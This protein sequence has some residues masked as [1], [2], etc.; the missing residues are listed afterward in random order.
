MIHKEQIT[1][2][3]AK[4]SS[5]HSR[6]QATK[7]TPEPDGTVYLRFTSHASNPQ[8]SN[9]GRQVRT[10]VACI[11]ISSEILK[12]FAMKKR[13]TT[14]TTTNDGQQKLKKQKNGWDMLLRPKAK[15]FDTSRFQDIVD[16]P[17]CSGLKLICWLVRLVFVHLWAS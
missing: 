13:A 9:K 7:G 4:T 14:T 3:A 2:Y 8:P 12:T 17:S 10:Y 1:G 6:E 5:K 16:S 15:D 11:Q